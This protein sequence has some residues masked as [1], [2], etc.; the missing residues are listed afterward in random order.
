MSSEARTIK[1]ERDTT[2]RRGPAAG[3]LAV[4][5]PRPQADAGR[6]LS[7]AKQDLT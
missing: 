2:A 3:G 4:V 7:T 6:V 5:D 1:A